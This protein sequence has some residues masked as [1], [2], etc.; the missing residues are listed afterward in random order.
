MIHQVCG[1]CGDPLAI[2]DEYAGKKGRCAK[3]GATISVGQHVPPATISP[4]EAQ[5]GS[6]AK[7]ASAILLKDTNAPREKLSEDSYDQIERLGR[8]RASGAITE[9][10]FADLKGR[11]LSGSRQTRAGLSDSMAQ[12]EDHNPPA[13]PRIPTEGFVKKTGLMNKFSEAVSLL[14][15]HLGLFAAIILTVWLPGNL[16]V[17]RVAQ[18]LGEETGM[19]AM[20]LTWMIEG[21]FGPIYLGALVYAL[22]NIKMGRP[23]T[24]VEA[25]GVGFRKWGVLFSAR[26]VAGLLIMLGFVALIVPGIV[27]LVRYSLQDPA[28]VIEGKT[29]TTSRARS[30]ELTSGRRWQIF[31]AGIIFII[32]FMLLSLAVYLPLA[33]FESL[34]ITLVNVFLDSILDIGFAVIQIVMFLF[35][36]E[37]VGGKAGSGISLSGKGDL[38]SSPAA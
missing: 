13:A 20:R 11:I 4:F 12:S 22:Y 30:T 26:F 3:C 36:W 32:P 1:S 14:W 35:Y 18:S 34:D 6:D 29:T 15:A 27:L 33:F 37:S 19:E 28:V 23:V 17:N 24:Y 5:Q 31:N 9:E 2:P 38:P 25:M 10:E 8:L 21:I 16:V 7:P